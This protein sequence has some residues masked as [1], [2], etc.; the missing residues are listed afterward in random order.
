MRKIDLI[1]RKRIVL[2]ILSQK[3]GKVMIAEKVEKLEQENT[4]LKKQVQELL[5]ICK[6]RKV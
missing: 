6:S 3:G 4:V 1:R 5:E 2:F